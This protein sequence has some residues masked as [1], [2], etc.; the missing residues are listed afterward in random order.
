MKRRSI[1]SAL[2]SAASTAVLAGAL[3]AP[4]G[5]AL[6]AQA[7]YQPP[8]FDYGDGRIELGEAVRL[9]LAH[10]PNLLLARED[11]NV[12]RGIL[13]QQAGV[14]DWTVAFD[15]SYEHREQELRNSTIQRERDKRDEL[16]V[17]NQFACE[18]V[19]LQDA[20]I[21]QLTAN[22][23]GSPIDPADYDTNTDGFFQ[24]QLAFYEQRLL[25]ATDPAEIDALL[26]SRNALLTREL[27]IATGTRDEFRQLCAD[28]RESLDNLGSIPEFED[29]DTGDVSLGL[30]KLFRNGIGFAPFVLVTYD[31]TQ[32]PGKR[33]GFNE[34]R[35]DR[36]GNPILTEFG[37][38]LQRFV[39]FGGKNI[40]DLWTAEVGFDLN[41]PLLRGAG[42]VSTG[43]PERAAAIDVEASEA[44]LR[45]SAAV[46]ALNT[47]AAY[48]ALLAAQERVTV[49]E[50]SVDLQTRLLQLTDELIE[51][52]Q[53][54]RVER[55]RSLASQANARSQLEGAK[56]DLVSARMALARAMGVDVANEQNAP[57][58]APG[59]PATPSAD[60]V[61]ALDSASL[62]DAAVGTRFD[63][64]AAR[65]LVESGLILAEA[66]RHD[67]RD[68]L[69]LALSL[70]ANALGEK[71]FSEAID[72]W[73][74]PSGS[75]ALAYEKQVGNRSA[76]GLLG[77]QEALHRQRQI[78]ATD[79]ERTIRIAV[80]QTLGSLEQAIVRLEQ[81][82]AS[83]RYFQETI[84]AEVEKLKA[85]ASTII[86]TILTEQQR[87]S[88]DLS[89]LA[90]RQ[91]VATL[92]AQ[93]AFEAGLLVEQRGDSGSVHVERLT[94]L[95]AP[96]GAAGG[97]P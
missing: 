87:T 22:L 24:A 20:K 80:V 68:R 64:I 92:I 23:A 57:L 55:S 77:Q 13:G 90:A 71:S 70:S 82:E 35:L 91:Q 41:L 69:D 85:G 6:L 59:F 86:D 14:F 5:A 45:H 97:L 96:G 48:W 2:R 50:R 47:A 1:G 75:I 27:A 9:T 73:T 93:L 3:A 16:S 29:F 7:P 49:L 56:R 17:Q 58:A 79:L 11:V 88:A 76:L 43:A 81:A 21:Q 66:A 65:R 95:P 46:S 32:F 60:A 37:T 31:S 44:I 54:P 67:L 26:R 34:P 33:N 42:V 84:D 78:S 63:R 30:T 94:S 19:T 53:V 83:A 36:F 4:H 10:D 25:T 74:G 15:I 61:R 62:A 8:R 12:Q 18:Q 51:G 28:T 52:D 38:P 40:E 72:R 39:D 89:V